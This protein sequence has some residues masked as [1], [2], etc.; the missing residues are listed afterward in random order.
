MGHNALIIN[1]L[2]PQKAQ[3]CQN[4]DVLC[5]FG[6]FILQHLKIVDGSFGVPNP[7]DQSGKHTSDYENFY[8]V[9]F[10]LPE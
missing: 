3:V 9:S 7:F 10:F 4:S 8:G 2:Y 5:Q 1:V 6:V